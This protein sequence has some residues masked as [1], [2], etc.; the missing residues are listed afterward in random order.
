MVVE[1]A[2]A[3]RIWKSPPRVNWGRFAWVPSRILEIRVIAR[4]ELL[5][6]RAGE[7]IILAER[8]TST[9]PDP[10]QTLFGKVSLRCT[11]RSSG[12]PVWRAGLRSSVAEGE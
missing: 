2:L 6:P 10:M 9:W 4:G 7:P 3:A 12:L 11:F 8:V 5:G 1:T